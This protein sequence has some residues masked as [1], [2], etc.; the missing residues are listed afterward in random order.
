MPSLRRTRPE[1][2]PEPLGCQDNGS[3]GTHREELYRLL[4]SLQSIA[5]PSRADMRVLKRCK[6][7]CRSCKDWTLLDGNTPK[8]LVMASFLDE[9]LQHNSKFARDDP[10]AR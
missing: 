3:A 6:G 10:F 5:D 1:S 7:E 9:F 4:D 8:A 2:G